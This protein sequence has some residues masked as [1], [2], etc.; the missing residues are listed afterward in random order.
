MYAA[1]IIDISSDALDHAYTY[2]IP[3]GMKVQVGNRVTIPFGS[4]NQEK[5]GYVIELV[6][7]FDY[8]PSRVKDILTVIPDAISAQEQLIQLAAW[9]STEYGTTMNQCLKTVLPV[10]R[11]VRKNARRIDPLLHYQEERD[12]YHDL[13]PAQAEAAEAVRKGYEACLRR[14]GQE[15]M[16]TTPRYLLHGI[17]GS[18]KTEV[19]LHIMDEVLQHGE[20]VILL[21]PEISLTYQTV[22]RVSTRFQGRVAILNSRMSIGERY[23]QYQKCASGEVNVLIGPRSAVF[24]PFEH[25]GLII[26]DEEHESAYKSETAPRFETRDVAYMRA[27]M[28]GC[29]VLYGSATPSLTLYTAARAG[30]VSLLELPTR[31]H[32]GAQLPETEIIDLREELANGNR[33]ILSARLYGL[34]QEKLE[35]H[36]QIMLFMNRRGY[37]SF[38]SCRSCGEALKCPHCDITL[39][40]HRDGMLRCHYCGYQI[41]LMKLCPHC[42]SPYLA[43]FGFGTEKLESYV[44]KLFPNASVLRMDADTTR[45][46]GEHERI[47]ER[48]RRHQADILIGTQM[49]VKGHDFPD[50]TLVGII[51][52]DLSLSAPDFKASERTF[53][54]LTQ[55]AGRAGRGAQAGTVVIQTYQP[56]HYAIVL[57]KRQ[58]YKAFYAEEFRFR[59]LMGYP[60]T[61]RLMT[62][63]LAS[64]DEDFLSMVSQAATEGFQPD[65]SAAGAELIGPLEASVYRIKDIYRKI[66]YIK[67]PSHDI[68][69]RLRDYFTERVRQHDRR[70][71][72]LLNYDL[73]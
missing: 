53:Q 47:L 9:M 25:L 27:R 8:D 6:E 37:S 22:R 39:T 30:E 55:A 17:T 26:M 15:P 69:I 10:R 3:E 67:H 43:P 45:R 20:Q 19:Y 49:I 56:D 40:L 51:A 24:A 58:D 7:Q 42:G 66:V 64:K 2:H 18:G 14:R 29:P 28:A 12:E 31:A 72:V 16:S 48:F 59:K 23:E 38:V 62:I 60:P 46:K 41:R 50:V 21:I 57:S 70:G 34:M 65:C 52:A 61:E 36:E 68:I 33:S 73:Q 5:T 11:T 32:T 35:R 44:K 4:A 13:N 71:L 63:Q 54:L 1:I